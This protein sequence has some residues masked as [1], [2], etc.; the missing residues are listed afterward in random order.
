MVGEGKSKKG[1]RNHYVDTKHRYHR[2]MALAAVMFVVVIMTTAL[3]AINETD[4]SQADSFG[5]CGDDLTWT[6]TESDLS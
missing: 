4:N 2:I 6:Y 5:F 3:I 1:S